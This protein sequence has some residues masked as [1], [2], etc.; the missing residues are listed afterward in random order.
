MHK[1]GPGEKQNRFSRGPIFIARFEFLVRIALA[2]SFCSSPF[3]CNRTGFGRN[4]AI[5]QKEQSG[6]EGEKILYPFRL[7]ARIIVQ[8]ASE[9]FTWLL[10]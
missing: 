8:S 4:A 9:I 10:V 6:F 2:F 7:S 1:I 3:G 5:R